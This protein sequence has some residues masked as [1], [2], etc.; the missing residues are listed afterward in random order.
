M[1]E[2]LDVAALKQ[3]FLEARTYRAWQQRDISDE[4]LR[5]LISLMKMGPTASNS[6]PARLVFVK[7]RSGKERLMTHLNET[8]RDKTMGASVCAIVG[9]DVRFFEHPPQGQ[10]MLSGFEGKPEI[11]DRVALR[12]SSLQGAYLILA[13]RSLG[14]DAGPD[15]WV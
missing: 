3:L 2:K 7:S 9:Y 5:E 8:N 10:E 12:N 15:V 14:L 13:A 11:A 1:T 4:L 6:L